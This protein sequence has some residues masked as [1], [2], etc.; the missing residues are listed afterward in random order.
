MHKPNEI[1][2]NMKEQ[3]QTNLMS[4]IKLFFPLDEFFL[5]IREVDK[6]VEGLLVDVAVA[7]QFCIALL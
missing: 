7:L 1:T 6:L 3:M 2:K 4:S 5:L